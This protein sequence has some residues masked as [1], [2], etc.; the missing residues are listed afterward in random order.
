MEYNIIEINKSKVA[1]LITGHPWVFSGALLCKYPNLKNGEIVKLFCNSNYVATG[2]FNNNSIAFKVLSFNENDVIDSAFIINN[3]KSIH[4]NKKSLYV[5]EENNGFRLVNADAD[6][7]PGLIIDVFHNL[8]VFQV[9]SILMESF[10]ADIILALKQLNFAHIVEKSDSESRKLDGLLV[11]KPIIHYGVQQSSYKFLENGITM[12]CDPLCGQKTGFFLD[13]KLARNWL[14]HNSKNKKVVNLFSYSG[15]FGVS[16]LIGEARAVINVDV[17]KE[18]LQLAEL[19]FQENNA[20][21]SNCLYSCI[22]SDVFEYLQQDFQADVLI[23]DPPAFAKNKAS[24]DNAVKAYVKINAKCLS[25]L[26]VGNIFIT[27]SCSGL[28]KMEDFIN[29]IKKACLQAN[30]KVKILHE[31]KQH[32]DHSIILGFK[33]GEY[34]KT[35]I[36]EII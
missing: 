34:L 2:V 24:L 27:S 3:I 10:I 30:K 35:L 29:I 9:S 12:L 16:A 7:L 5:N 36:L 21:N 17:S 26:S 14:K 25:K 11:K 19:I 23:C 31:F 22:K 32:S 18:A 6:Y 1:P 8:A 28:L 20:S 13:Q 4:N 15:G 33:E